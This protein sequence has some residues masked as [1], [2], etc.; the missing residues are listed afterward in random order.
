M[1]R[2]AWV[3]LLGFAFAIPWEYSLDLG[4]PLGNVARIAG[5]LLLLV[6]IPAVLQAG[7]MRRPG[8]LQWL[9]LALLVWFCCSGFWT[10]DQ[11]MT[12]AKLR[13]YFQE[14]MIVWLIWEIAESPRDLRWLLRAFLA[15]S[16]VLAILT[17]ADFRSFDAM[18]AEQVRFAAYGQDPNDVARFLDLGFPLAALL[19][20]GNAPWGDN[21][22]ALG[23]LPLGVVA[24]I[25]TASRGGFLAAL[26][27][28]AACGA[29]LARGRPRALVAAFLS[30]PVLGGILWATIPRGTIARLATI[31]E[32]LRQGN[33]N[34]RLNIW[35]AGWHAF[36]R[37]PVLGAGAGTFVQAAR[38]APVDTAHNSAL[39]IAVTGGLCALCLALAIFAV[40]LGMAW[41]TGGRLRLALTAALLVWAVSSLVG[42]VEESR[43][44]WLLFA[45]IAVAARLA[46]EDSAALATWFPDPSRGEFAHLDAPAEALDG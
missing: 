15:G 19:A 8:A 9:S 40:V 17:L 29:I 2:V 31:P 46:D 5:L 33:L 25:L 7:C 45:L 18:L 16:W 36:A 23:Y 32:Q 12:L 26:V 6:T 11:A 20:D 1:R 4:P 34:Q 28:L 10:I 37:A 14:T 38:L 21:V 43:T 30:A 42:T 44:T 39:S 13:G 22:L 41:S 24:V 27:A 35:T 3:L